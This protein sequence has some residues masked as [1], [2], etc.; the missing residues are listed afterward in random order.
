MKRTTLKRRTPLRADP[1]KTR[2]WRDRSRK[3]MPKTG[4]RTKKRQAMNRRIDK[5]LSGIGIDR[6]EIRIQG[7]CVN[8]IMLTHAHSKK[9][10]FL[11]TDGDWMEAALCCIPCHDHIEAMPHG[12][13]HRIVTEAIA[14]RPKQPCT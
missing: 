6:C 8:S 3:P 5:V 1:E 13:M 14:R 12:D 2:A 11:V 10:R 7:K 4:P 9:S